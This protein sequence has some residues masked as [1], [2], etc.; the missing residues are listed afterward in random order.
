VH[1]R[2]TSLMSLDLDG[3]ATPAEQMELA[4]HLNEGLACALIWEQWK[5][6]D[7]LLSKMPCV[8]PKRDLTVG[9][10][11]KPCQS[12]PRKPQRF[13]HPPRRR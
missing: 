7:R 3:V 9:S 11:D 4:R 10:L 13:F 8:A 1:E 12:A 2:F 6:I 5:A